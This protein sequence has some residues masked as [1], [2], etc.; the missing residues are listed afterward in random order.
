MPAGL[1]APRAPLAL[2]VA[3]RGEDRV[4]H[5][6]ARELDTALRLKMLTVFDGLS[7][8]SRRH[9]AGREEEDEGAARR[10]GTVVRVIV[11]IIVGVV[12]LVLVAACRTGCGC[13]TRRVGLGQRGGRG[14]PFAGASQ[15]GC[16]I[17]ACPVH[18]N[19][20]RA[21]QQLNALVAVRQGSGHKGRHSVFAHRVDLDVVDC[22]EHLHARHVASIGRDEERCPSVIVRRIDLDVVDCQE[23]LHARRV[24]SISSDVERRP[25]VLVR[26]IDLDVVDC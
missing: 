22:Q 23:H 2:P 14:A 1:V 24:A 25:S 9:A 17:W 10:V 3:L 12:V 5:R 11:R 7:Q 6:K 21:Q 18:V 26:R 19:A 20:I 16:A 13:P 15:S 4:G 8:S